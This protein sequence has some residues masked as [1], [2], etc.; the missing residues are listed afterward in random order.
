MNIALNENFKS[1]VKNKVANGDYNSST[2]VVHEALRLL[3]EQDEK[4]QVLK[5]EIQKGIVSIE[6]GQFSTKSMAEL[7][8]ESL[9]KWKDVQKQ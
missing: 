3:Q 8:D 6:A 9:A 7:F 2:D 4:K 1:Y 5:N